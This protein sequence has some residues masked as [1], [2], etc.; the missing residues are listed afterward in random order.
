MLLFQNPTQ[1]LVSLPDDNF[2]RDNVRRV[3]SAGISHVVPKGQFS[4]FFLCFL[5]PSLTEAQKL[6]LKILSGWVGTFDSDNGGFLVCLHLIHD[7]VEEIL[8]TALR[9]IIASPIVMRKQNVAKELRSQA[10]AVR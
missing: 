10:L 1:A 5:P 2:P 7:S 6:K 3:K 8:I 4:L 9:Q